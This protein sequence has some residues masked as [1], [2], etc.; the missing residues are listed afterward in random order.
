MNQNIK[1][2]DY[3][4]SYEKLGP[5]ELVEVKQ[6][7]NQRKHSDNRQLFFSDLFKNGRE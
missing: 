2:Q 1:V 6:D 7:K 5:Y 3:F 4:Q